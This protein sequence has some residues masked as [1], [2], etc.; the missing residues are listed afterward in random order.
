MSA[1]KTALASGAG[2][3]RRPRR[4][5]ALTEFALVF[6]VFFLVVS[7]IIQFGLL[8]WTMN[9]ATQVARDTARWAVTQ[10]TAPCDS[11]ANRASLAATAGTIAQELKLLGYTAG[12]WTTATAVGAVP[13]EGIGADW[14]IP[15]GL[16]DTDCPPADNQTPWFVSVRVNHVVPVF[17]PGIQLFFPACGGA[18][19]CISTTAEVRMEPKV[20]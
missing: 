5:Q 16:F 11:T 7:A 19:I 3:R 4:G 12:M 18:G 13:A 15:T 14:P 1:S 9:T 2:H 20:P 8:L 17:L 6:G 10:S